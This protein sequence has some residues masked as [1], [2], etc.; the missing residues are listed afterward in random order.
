[1]VRHRLALVFNFQ[2]IINTPLLKVFDR[3][4]LYSLQ[5]VDKPTRTSL[6][7]RGMQ[8]S[9]VVSTIASSA[10]STEF[11][12]WHRR[13][14]KNGIC[15]L[16]FVICRDDMLTVHCPSD[17]GIYWRSPG[18]CMESQV[19]MCRLKNPTFSNPNDY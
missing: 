7:L 17:W 11:Y 16:S 12:H 9:S 8:D 5:V 10:R 1:M 2:Y 18:L 19:L 6:H 14:K 15:T 3:I 13:E 4:I